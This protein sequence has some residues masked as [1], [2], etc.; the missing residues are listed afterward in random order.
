MSQYNMSDHVSNPHVGSSWY[1]DTP[2]AECLGDIAGLKEIYIRNRD[3]H[4]IQ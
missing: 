2:P 3:S 1:H 4:T